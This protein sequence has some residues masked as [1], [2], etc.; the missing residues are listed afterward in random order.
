MKTIWLCLSLLLLVPA[1][2]FNQTNELDRAQQ[3]IYAK[4][5][6][7]AKTVLQNYLDS[8]TSA[9]GRYMLSKV[10]YVLEEID[11]AIDNAKAAVNLDEKNAEY[12]YWLGVCYG[13]Q[14]NSASVIKQP[15]LAKKTQK[16]FLQAVT[17]DSTHFSARTAL[18]QYYLRAPGI[19][20]GDINKAYEHVRILMKQDEVEGRIL[21][22][23]VYQRD[24]KDELADKEYAELEEKI[25]DNPDYYY[26]FNSYGYYLLNKG[27]TDL[28]IRKFRKQVELAPDNPNA[29]DSLGEGL[30]KKGLLKESLAEYQRALE[31][32]PGL[33]SA[34]VKVEEIESR[35]ND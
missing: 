29:H 12:H 16:A 33:K 15:F 27:E 1:F 6:K 4:Q 35:L 28:A 18:A 25:G 8:G 3:H 9:Q 23:Q 14:T 2:L 26:F 34:K 32:D 19:M 11:A 21:L 30:L 20:G 5:Y 31:L 10:H 17:L 7:E 24:N 13:A 22:A